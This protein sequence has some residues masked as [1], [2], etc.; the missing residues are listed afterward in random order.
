LLKN[1]NNHLLNVYSKEEYLKGIDNLCAYYSNYKPA[2]KE[3]FI[4][5]KSWMSKDNREKFFSSVIK[6]NT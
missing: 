2:D 6:I 3:D 5:K 1:L 4:I